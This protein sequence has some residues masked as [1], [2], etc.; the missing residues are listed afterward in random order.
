M[1]S[2]QLYVVG[3]L[4]I[5]YILLVLIFKR[6]YPLIFNTFTLNKKIKIISL[7]FLMTV[8]YGLFR[9]YIRP[10]IFNN[11]SNSTLLFILSVFPNFIGIFIMYPVP[12]YLLDHTL[13]KSI[14]Y[15]LV[16]I[17]IY[18]LLHIVDY[19]TSFDVYDILSSVLALLII[20]FVERWRLRKSPL[21]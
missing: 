12:K 5:S 16:S 1:N 19:N 10:Y 3:C 2:Q 18:E 20:Y 11:S 4:L 14:V 6:R 15:L 21:V 8:F 7:M 17:I 9:H 13:N